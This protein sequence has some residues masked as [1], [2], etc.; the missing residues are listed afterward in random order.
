MPVFERM[1]LRS[2]IHYSRSEA[3]SMAPVLCALSRLP[4]SAAPWFIIL[5]S[6][7]VPAM[8]HSRWKCP[9]PRNTDT[10]I[11]TGPC[12]SD[13]NNFSTA[14]GNTSV[15]EL[16]PG[17]LRVYFEESIY[18]TGAPF[19]IALSGDGTDDEVCILLDHIPHNDDLS[20]LPNLFDA[21]TYTPYSIT[22][23]IPDVQCDQC[24]L[25]LVNPMTD[26]IGA[27]GAPDGV[28]CTDPNGSCFSVYHSCTVPFRILGSVARAD[29]SCPAL[30]SDWPTQWT[31]DDGVSVDVSVAGTY[32]REASVW[33]SDGFLQ[34]APEQY[35]LDVGGTCGPQGEVICAPPIG[36]TVQNSTQAPGLIASAMPSSS[37]L[38][39]TSSRSSAPSFIPVSSS[40]GA[41]TEVPTEAP[42]AVDST[43]RAPTQVAPTTQVEIT[44]GANENPAQSI[45][46][47]S[48]SSSHRLLRRHNAWI[49]I[50]PC[51]V[52]FALLS[53]VD[54]L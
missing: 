16:Q 36:P 44:P 11:K 40:S 20:S 7:I 12:G 38:A 28:G 51:I 27:D 4:S 17:P 15:L 21:S 49:T 26:K 3:S 37:P 31:G 33:S 1:E 32:R 42:A 10:G 53:F 45:P 35:R 41:A 30:P 19:R 23:N 50:M 9:A 34:T 48:S 25:H 13:T 46:V 18:H 29:Y 24:S 39:T 47:T 22:I 2:I 14:D 54:K 43:S 6:T 5:W 8:A 52:T